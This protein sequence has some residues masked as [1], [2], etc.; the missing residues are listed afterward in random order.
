[1]SLMA[2]NP[3]IFRFSP[4]LAQTGNNQH[5][6]TLQGR[7]ARI[8]VGTDFSDRSELALEMA[9]GLAR[10][11]GSELILAH[12]MSDKAH[13]EA[14]QNTRST[15]AEDQPTY[16][17][18]RKLGS[19]LEHRDLGHVNTRTLVAHGNPAERMVALSKELHPDLIV[20]AP[21]AKSTLERL[22]LGSTARSLLRD[23]RAPVWIARPNAKGTLRH[24]AVAMDYSPA[25]A[26]ALRLAAAQALRQRAPLTLLH[27]AKDPGDIE[28]HAG[29][30]P[31]QLDVQRQAN[32][33][34][35]Q[36]TQALL[37]QLPKRPRQIDTHVLYGPARQEL[38]RYAHSQ[39]I[40]L[41]VIGHH[42]Q[43]RLL[44][45]LRGATDQTLL[46]QVP[47]SL[48]VTRDPQHH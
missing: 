48:L 35:R 41:L 39:N 15:R 13:Q 37:E 11:D 9:L 23:A 46:D 12:V 32:E 47:C 14:A 36:H 18:K 33:R 27:V 43:S 22:W 28:V 16:R 21:S 5:P 4:A 31:G 2:P 42:H 29:Q 3:N 26:Q 25:S 38:T 34:F 30:R 44:E 24:I 19:H 20:V 17:L 7:F 10:R 40:D 1:M 8:L 45:T 6:T